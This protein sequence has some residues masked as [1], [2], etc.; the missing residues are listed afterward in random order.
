MIY[1]ALLRAINV[2]G[3]SLIS[4][5]DLRALFESLGFKDVSSYIQTGNVIFST[6]EKNKTAL[7]SH[8]EGALKKKFDYNTRV[9]ILTAKELEQAAANNPFEPKRLDKQQHCHLVFLSSSP[10]ADKQKAL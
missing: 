8:I 1:V 7:A 9:F 6:S 4:M 10:K 3:R 2:G 5:P